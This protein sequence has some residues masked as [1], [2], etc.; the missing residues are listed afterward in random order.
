VRAVHNGTWSEAVTIND[1]YGSETAGSVSD[2]RNLGGLQQRKASR[3]ARA[4]ATR[5]SSRVAAQEPRTGAGAVALRPAL[6]PC[7]E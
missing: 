2:L 6:R 7:D 1:R 4:V 5:A 3:H